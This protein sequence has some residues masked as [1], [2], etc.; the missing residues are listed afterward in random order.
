[1]STKAKKTLFFGFIFF[2]LLFFAAITSGISMLETAIA[3]FVNQFK[4]TREKATII[5]SSIIGL[6]SIPATLSFSVLSDL[7]ITGKTMH[8]VVMIVME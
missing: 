7:K 6:I 2:A 8:K 5:T 3:S 4:I 1:M